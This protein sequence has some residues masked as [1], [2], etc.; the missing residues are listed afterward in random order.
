ML[1]RR[2]NV[3]FADNVPTLGEVADFGNEICQPCTKLELKT[4]MIINREPRHIAYVLL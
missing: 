2:S 3:A 4:K 1:I